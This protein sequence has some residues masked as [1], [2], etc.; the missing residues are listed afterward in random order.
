MRSL[1][2]VTHLGE[3]TAEVARHLAIEL[4][5]ELGISVEWHAASTVSEITEHGADLYWMCGLLTTQLI[6]SGRL[7]GRIVAA[8]VFPGRTEPVYHS[9]IVATSPL[10]AGLRGTTLAINEE[11]SWSGNHAL[12]VHLGHHPG[13]ASV[14]TTGSHEASIDLLLAGEAD[15]AAIDDTVWSHRL[16]RDPLLERLFVVDRTRDWPAPP[17][18]LDARVPPAMGD[19]LT[20]ALV[21][22]KPT[23]L[24][25]IDGVSDSDYDPIRSAMAEDRDW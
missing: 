1:H 15:V 17:F 12:R 6:D 8:P 10:E 5:N 4:E 7:T 25:R 3:N 19:S 9:V 16:A 2:L 11:G 21:R 24:I 20:S 22:A 18:T 23:G 14:A 13:F